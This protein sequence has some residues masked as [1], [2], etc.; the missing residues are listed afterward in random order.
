MH[1]K[2]FASGAA[3]RRQALIPKKFTMIVLGFRPQFLVL[4]ASSPF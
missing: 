4:G 3:S 2:A 1:Q